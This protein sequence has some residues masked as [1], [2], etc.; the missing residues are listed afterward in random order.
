LE[1]F[2]RSGYRT[3][4]VGKIFHGGGHSRRWLLD[5]EIVV[6]PSTLVGSRPKKKVVI[7]PQGGPWVDWGTWPHDDKDRG[8]YQTA[9]WAI[10]RIKNWSP[11]EPNFLA[12]GF[13]LPHVP[14]YP[15]L[16]TSC[17]AFDANC[18]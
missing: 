5:K 2:H 13:F 9:S 18:V 1:H 8:D 17:S 10:E 3:A 11:D 6:G 16:F 15:G 14:L 4:T 7:T 12:V